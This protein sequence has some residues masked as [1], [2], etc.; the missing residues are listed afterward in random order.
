M[1]SVHWGMNIFVVRT[2]KWKWSHSVMSY[3]ATPWT[4]AYQAPPS[5]GFSRQEYW[6]GLPCPSPG[7]LPNPGIKPGSPAFQADA[8]SSEPPGKPITYTFLSILLGLPNNL[9]LFVFNVYIN[10]TDF[11]WWLTLFTVELMQCNFWKLLFFLWLMTA[12][13]LL[14]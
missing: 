5:M 11:I 3:S 12:S 14:P 7:D 2:G 1:D 8:L 9:L 6:S 4:V 10:M 13:I